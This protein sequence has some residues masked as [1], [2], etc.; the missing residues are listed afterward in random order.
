MKDF[1]REELSIRTDDSEHLD[2]FPAHYRVGRTK[3]V[4]VTGGVM[5]GVGKGVFTASL[6]HLLQFLG[7]S[8]STIKIDGYLNLD[9]GTLNPY[10][11]GE[12]FVLDDG[13]ECDLDLGTYERFLD[14]T[15]NGFNYMTAGNIS[16]AMSRSSHTSRAKLNISCV[17]RPKKGRTTW[18]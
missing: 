11:H 18:C 10:R 12:T 7:F 16:G 9:A 14:T 2:F 17:R 15:L 3:Y 8:V 6:S 13:T 1:D 5:S 4:I